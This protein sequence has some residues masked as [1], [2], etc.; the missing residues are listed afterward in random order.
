MNLYHGARVAADELVS[1][2]EFPVAR[3]AAN[4][5][6]FY[7]TNNINIARSYGRVIKYVVDV[8]WKCSLMRPIKVGEH[9]GVEYVLTQR[10][11]DALV[12]DHALTIE[13]LP[14]MN[15]IT[16]MYPVY[17]TTTTEEATMNTIPEQILTV[18][19]SMEGC[20]DVVVT[21]HLVSACST[22]TDMCHHID[23]FSHPDSHATFH[24]AD[25]VEVFPMVDDRT[26]VV[27]FS[28]DPKDEWQ[29]Y[30]SP[31]TN[32]EA[33]MNTI[34][35]QPLVVTHY[36]GDWKNDI[37][38]EDFEYACGTATHM[39]HDKR[40]FY[41]PDAYATF[42]TEDG[43]EVFPMVDA[44]AMVVAFSYNP[45]DEWKDYVAP[46][47]TEEA[48]MNTTPG[49]TVTVTDRDTQ[50]VAT[51]TIVSHIPEAMF[52]ADDMLGEYCADW[53]HA[54]IMWGDDVFETYTAELTDDQGTV[55][56][57]YDNQQ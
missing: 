44:S 11:A 49:Y 29:V 3:K 9:V 15:A 46:T 21:E 34:T 20:E 52:E 7:L 19:Y 22:A 51:F 23:D 41:H 26:V 40:E 12:V 6:G 30:I 55:R 38:L 48:P 16:P 47:T 57:Y 35:E 1:Y 36:M 45:K 8:N 13:V 28:T 17:P 24:T 37:V 25:G 56:A 53:V 27:E 33:P 39:C 50:Q 43:V 10:E 4:G 31:T 5:L 42:H 18:T 14:L 2:S 32:E 54:C